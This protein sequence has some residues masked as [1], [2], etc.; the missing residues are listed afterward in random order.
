[1]NERA[2]DSMNVFPKKVRFCLS[3]LHILIMPM[4]NIGT[5]S[6]SVTPIRSK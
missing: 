3:D 4:Q 2:K 5:I 6:N 1:M